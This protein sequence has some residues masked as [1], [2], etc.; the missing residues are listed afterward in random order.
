MAAPTRTPIA[1]DHSICLP[2]YWG[3][4]LAGSSTDSEVTRLLGKGH[5]EEQHGV[6][7]ARYFTD[8]SKSTTLK[9]EYGTDLLVASAELREGLDAS[10]SPEIA[11]EMVS[12]WLRPANG[13]GVWS[14]IRLGDSQ[15]AVRTN[16]GEPSEIRQEG[17]ETVWSYESACACELAT[18]LSFSFRADRLVAFSIWALM[19]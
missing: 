9:V 2:P 14:G 19:G 6:V 11:D 10:I 15:S 8:L 1:N 18:G 13:L 17:N 7:G 5:F 3:G 4:L 12:Q 16:L